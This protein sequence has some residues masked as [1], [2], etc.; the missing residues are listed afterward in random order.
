MSI[1]QSF[2]AADSTRSTTPWRSGGALYTI[3]IVVW[4]V[5]IAFSPPRIPGGDLICFKD[6]AINFARGE[7]LVSRLDPG[8]SGL[9]PKTYSNYPPLFSILYGAFVRACGVGLKPDEFFDFTGCALAALLF[10]MVVVPKRA[11][12]RTSVPALVLL[13]MLLA[14][15]PVGPFWSQRERPDALAFSFVMLG[16]FALRA[17]HCETG[18]AVAGLIAGINWCLSP[19]GGVLSVAC[20]FVVGIDQLKQA[21]SSAVIWRCVLLGIFGMAVPLL[22]LVATFY[23]R[24]LNAAARFLAVISGH[25]TGG[26]AGLGYILSIL[27]GD[28]SHFLAAFLRF[29]NIRY[30]AMGAHLLFVIGLVVVWISFWWKD[31]R[32][33]WSWLSLLGIL[34]L[35]I[36][37]LLLF[38]YQP[39]YMSFTA[40]V[41]IA[42]L[43]QFAHRNLSARFDPVW[44]AII[45]FGFVAFPAGL[46]LGRELCLLG[47]AAPSLRKIDNAI[48]ALEKPETGKR[49]LV[50]TM[51]S[52]YFS[53]K[54]R[55]FDVVDLAYLRRPEDIAQIDYFAVTAYPADAAA[56]ELNRLK[57]AAPLAEIYQP[58]P[59][60]SSAF[61]KGRFAYS[62]ETWIMQRR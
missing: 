31:I 47:K 24:D 22:V 48:S 43:V 26:Q 15:L 14:I 50:A 51:A 40:T 6:A 55:R 28:V 25:S 27:R 18:F 11:P 10:W 57:S 52:S 46:Y 12:P 21:R 53:F 41:V 29:D 20:L 58:S 35:S 19:Y 62:W 32:D 8:N 23:G 38:P 1:L 44:L 61:L 9:T 4:I 16:L 33:F 17:R 37:P 49:P 36:L 2:P 7:G 39:C 13:V 60:Y 3:A 59:D 56:S 34:A 54:S 5:F 42:L 30:K 45:A